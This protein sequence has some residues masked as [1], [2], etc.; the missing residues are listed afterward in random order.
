[1]IAYDIRRLPPLPNARNA[2]IL[3]YWDDLRNT[4]DILFGPF[5]YPIHPTT[6][7]REYWKRA[8][9]SQRVAD[10]EFRMW[11]NAFTGMSTEPGNWKNVRDHISAANWK[12]ES[13]KYRAQA[14]GLHRE[15]G[16]MWFSEAEKRK[17]MVESRG[18]RGG[19]YVVTKPV[20]S[21]TART[22]ASFAP[23]PTYPVNPKAVPK[24]WTDGKVFILYDS[25]VGKGT[26]QIVPMFTAP[27]AG[28]YWPYYS[29][30]FIGV[31]NGVPESPY[32]D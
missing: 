16:D 32:R 5:M 22:A 31:H 24:Y 3:Q 17:T 18:Q 11:R 12:Q 30:G 20:V 19:G 6:R 28:Q 14:A 2:Y 1:M 15:I 10:I 25:A 27:I 23:A 4:E 13:N 21:S 26:Y 29:A 9:N 8:T 7:M